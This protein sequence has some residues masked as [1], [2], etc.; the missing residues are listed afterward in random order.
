MAGRGNHF[1]GFRHRSCSRG[2][3][4]FPAPHRHRQRAH[5]V[6]VSMEAGL[7]LEHD[8]SLDGG[9]NESVAGTAA[10]TR[11]NLTTHDSRSS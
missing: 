9:R 6:A 5:H 10:D 7:S 8:R 2:W 11:R 3:L 4:G 1:R